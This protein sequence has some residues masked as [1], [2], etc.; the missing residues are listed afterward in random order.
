MK[1]LKVINKVFRIEKKETIKIKF[2]EKK[3]K[4]RKQNYNLINKQ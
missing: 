4:K 2:K 1:G 3:I